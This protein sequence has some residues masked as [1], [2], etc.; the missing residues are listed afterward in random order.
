MR[1]RPLA[2]PLHAA[3]ALLLAACNS[4][5][6][7]ND[8]SFDGAA[9]AAGAAGSGLGGAAGAAGAAGGAACTASSIKG[10]ATACGVCVRENCCE[11]LQTCDTD[12]ACAQCAN[13][14]RSGGAM[15]SCSLDPKFAKLVAC[16]TP[17][18]G[19][20]CKAGSGGGAGNECASEVTTVGCQACCKQALPD[21]EASFAASVGKNCK[22][23]AKCEQDCGGGCDGPKVGALGCQG[24]IARECAGPCDAG[25]A[26]CALYAKCLGG[27]QTPSPGGPCATTKAASGCATCCAK[28]HPTSLAAVEADQGLTTCR[29]TGLAPSCE[30]SCTGGCKDSFSD[31]TCV[32]CLATTCSLLCETKNQEACEGYL[33]C[34]KSC[35]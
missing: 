15:A 13:D 25:D 29:C 31:P 11:A 32:T 3:F 34:A 14:A 9:G 33:A 12:A 26:A 18:C 4:L 19:A 7:A 28:A 6:G 1:A 27:C 22:C 10:D 17:A 21:G 2:S 8:L 24:C 16:T 30:A 5:T 35:P 23:P 20:A